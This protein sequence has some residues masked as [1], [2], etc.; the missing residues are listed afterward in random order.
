MKIITTAFCFLKLNSTCCNQYFCKFY[1]HVCI[2]VK[3]LSLAWPDNSKSF[4]VCINFNVDKSLLF[5]RELWQGSLVPVQ[6]YF[7]MTAL[8][9]NQTWS[10]QLNGRYLHNSYTLPISLCFVRKVQ[11]VRS[12]WGNSCHSHENLPFIIFFF[13]NINFFHLNVLTVCFLC[14][15]LVWH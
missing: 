4:E 1:S 13:H 2:D 9:V 3:M 11:T 5:I 15:F 14:C 6:Q 12:T 10:L 8:S 7:W